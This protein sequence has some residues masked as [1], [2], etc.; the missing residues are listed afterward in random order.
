MNPTNRITAARQNAAPARQ[1]I[2]DEHQFLLDK[3]ARLATAAQRTPPEQ[4]TT[5]RPAEND[6][7]RQ[8]RLIAT[9]NAARNG[10][11]R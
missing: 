7:A 3:A 1:G 2:I 5:S 4:P 8:A 9:L 6:G 11:A 10:A